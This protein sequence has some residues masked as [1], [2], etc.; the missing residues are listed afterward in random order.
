MEIKKCPFC[1]SEI[2][3]AFPFLYEMEEGSW[4]LSHYCEKGFPL[5]VTI[6][7]YGASKEKVVEIWNRRWQ[8]A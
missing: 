5:S 4:L 8:D 1:G 6:D 3:D 7:V 2:K